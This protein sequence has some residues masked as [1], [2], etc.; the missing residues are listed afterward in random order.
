MSTTADWFST[1]FNTEY[2]HILYKHRDFDEARLFMANLVSYTNLKINDTVLDLACGKGRHSIFLN[3]LG[4]DVTGADL[5]KNSIQFA[6]KYENEKLKFIQH[7]M[8]HSFTSKFDAIFNLFTSF[9]YFIDDVEDIRVLKNIKNG[10]KNENGVAVIDYLNVKKAANNLPSKETI[11]RDGITFNIHKHLKDGFIIKEIEVITKNE[12]KHFFER[13]KYLD[14]DKIK[15]Y[16]TKVGLNLKSNFG[17]YDLQ[18]FNENTSNRLIL[19]L[20]K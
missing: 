14:F 5:S 1:W 7:D 11:K 4:L 3:S 8:R 9:G 16:L 17:D 20:T 19:I 2:Y 13:V 12:T 15:K 18:S 6:K 10:L